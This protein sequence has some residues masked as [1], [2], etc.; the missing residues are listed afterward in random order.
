MP[1]QIIERF[2]AAAP[3]AATFRRRLPAPARRFAVLPSQPIGP[4]SDSPTERWALGYLMDV[5]MTRDPW[6]HRTDIALVTGRE[7]TL[8]A[9]HDGAIVADAAREWADRH[10]QPVHLE[11]TGPAGGTWTWGEGGPPLVLDAVE[12]CRVL[13][14]RSH[15]DGLLAVEVP[16]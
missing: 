5:I 16:F 11:L 8:T 13:A 14:S 3:R 7:M 9:E 12:F 15:G 6:M 2:V 10:G 4:R 1:D